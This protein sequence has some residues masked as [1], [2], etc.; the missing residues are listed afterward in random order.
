MHLV[1]QA[2][3]V[4]AR[5]LV[6]DSRRDCFHAAGQGIRAG[7]DYP[8][9]QGAGGHLAHFPG[10]RAEH[11]P[12]IRQADTA[13]HTDLVLPRRTAM[14]RQPQAPREQRQRTTGKPAGHPTLPCKYGL[15]RMRQLALVDGGSDPPSGPVSAR[16]EALLT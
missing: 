2:G 5:E 4:I 1:Q 13:T 14:G 12:S 8:L 15:V 10:Q 11:L 6:A 7:L 9:L 16:W 3:V